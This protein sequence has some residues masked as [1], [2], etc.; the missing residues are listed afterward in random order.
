MALSR[1]T[2]GPL[3]ARKTEM[4]VWVFPVVSPPVVTAVADLVAPVLAAWRQGRDTDTQGPDYDE[5]RPR[6]PP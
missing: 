5:H 3:H 4:G 1:K 2:G 6:S